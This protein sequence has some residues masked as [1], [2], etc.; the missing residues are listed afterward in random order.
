MDIYCTSDQQGK[1]GYQDRPVK[2]IKVESIRI[3]REDIEAD[4]ES[5]SEESE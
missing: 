3:V 4:S 1:R 5:S 2:P